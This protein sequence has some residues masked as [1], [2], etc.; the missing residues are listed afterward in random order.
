MNRIRIYLSI[1]LFFFSFGLLSQTENELNVKFS[2]NRNTYSMSDL[3][4]F[5]TDPKTYDSN[6]YSET[7][8]DKVRSGN[9]FSLNIKYQWN[10]FFDVG[11]YGS[12]QQGGFTRQHSFSFYDSMVGD[13]VVVE[14][15]YELK[16]F[17]FGTGISSTVYLNHLLSH[18]SNTSRNHLMY[19]VNLMSGI[20]FATVQDLFVFDFEQQNINHRAQ[21]FQGIADLFVEFPLTNSN[22]MS[23]V[24]MNIGYQYFKT[25]FVRNSVGPE[26]PNTID[27]V[28]LKLD[29]SGVFFGAY[30][31]IRN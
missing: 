29:F 20:G 19:G 1:A 3:N 27:P 15:D 14:F 21:S 10:Q 24:G 4:Q 7:P 26:I 9:H 31:N 17:A 30:L 23:S 16:S 6:I 2:Y 8:S 11:I 5:L 28:K 13:T 12:Y 22:F 25:G 18:E